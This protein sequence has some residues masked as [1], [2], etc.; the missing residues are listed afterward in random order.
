MSNKTKR[1]AKRLGASALAVATIASGLSF[2]AGAASAAPEPR[3]ATDYLITNDLQGGYLVVSAANVVTNAY[4]PTHHEDTYAA[5]RAWA[6]SNN[7]PKFT[8]PTGENETGAIRTA[9]GTRCLNYRGIYTQ[10]NQTVLA[11]GSLSWSTSCA[12]DA[13][14][15]GKGSGSTWQY[16]NGWLFAVASNNAADA[17]VTGP[18]DRFRLLP[19][20]A[21]GNAP[22]DA[23]IAIIASNTSTPAGPGVVDPTNPPVDGAL[24]AAVTF[25]AD[26]AQSAVISGQAEAG[27]TVTFTAGGTRIGTAVADADG[28][29]T[30]N[31]PAPNRAGDYAVTVASD[32]ETLDVTAAY[33]DG[34]AITSPADGSQQSGTVTVRGTGQNGA[35]VTVR[36]NGQSIAPVTVANGTWSANL[37]A[38]A[39]ERTITATQ[40]SKGANTTTST[41]TVNPGQSAN[42]PL[43]VTVGDVDSDA[44]SAQVSGTATPGAQIRVGNTTVATAAADGTWSGRLTGLQVGTNAVEFVQFVDGTRVDAQTVDI[45]VVATAFELT[46]PKNNDVVQTA[47]KSVTFTGRGNP[48]GKVSILN[49][50]KQIGT[51]IVGDDGTWTFTATMAYTDYD[52]TVYYKKVATGAVTERQPLHI[53]V[54]NNQQN[55][56][57]EVTTPKD[58][59]T[60]QAPDKNVTF[61][62]TGTTGGVVTIKKSRV[63]VGT[64]EVDGAGRW[65]L[66]GDLN[67]ATHQLT[68]YYKKT[69][70]SSA[71]S[72]PLTITVTDGSVVKPFEVTD[73]ASGDTVETGDKSVTF[74]G[75]GAGGGAVVVKKGNATVA[76]GLV[77]DDGDW[78]LT[79]V[80]NYGTHDLT[81][82]H[83]PVGATRAEQVRLTVTVQAPPAD[84]AISTP[85]NGD[86]VA[87]GQVTFTGVGKDGTTVSVFVASKVR[88]TATVVDGKWTLDTT[89]ISAGTHDFVVYHKQGAAAATSETVRL[90]LR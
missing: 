71:V 20:S 55:A 43:T 41:V 7:A 16:R 17:G 32:G 3:Q 19:N 14:G 27:A 4:L 52:L 13:P 18:Y 25:P 53:T 6:E 85:S 22:A 78:S 75:H 66:T 35:R 42:A 80:L 24:T 58:G 15:K 8:F 67:F 88:G 49:G 74:N 12:I 69:P 79:G 28:E 44:R 40:S 51:A 72:M 77:G 48:G 2:G 23:K 29:Y 36:S 64:A 65:E 39:G 30:F 73:P 21:Q 26:N 1:V 57:F 83:K 82:F 60:V 11:T 86:T 56:P 37:A 90:T 59:S 84:F 76:S 68:A 33:G 10:Y 31:L 61:T 81:V 50:N 70:T 63:T 89:S 87:A 38:A 45:R 54:T 62:G 34:V 9:D 5:A 47:D 46:S